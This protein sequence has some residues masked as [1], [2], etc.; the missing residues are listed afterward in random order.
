[1]LLTSII[2]AVNI[3]DM[4]KRRYDMTGRAAKAAATKQRICDCAIE[5]YCSR[6]IEDFTLEEVAARAA[7]TVQT[8]LR[9]FGSKDE[10]IYAALDR[11]ARGGVFLKPT[12]PGDAAAAVT[13]FFEIYESIGDMVMRRLNEEMRRPALKPVLDEGRKHHRLGVEAAFAPH[14]ALLSAAP[15][16]RLLAALTVL[17]DVYV[18]KLV[19]RDMGFSRTASEAI[20]LQMING[21]IQ[22][23]TTD[24][25]ADPLAKLVRRREP[26]A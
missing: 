4:K 13:A 14:L 19:R 18:W 22:R 9:D 15:R 12:P 6:A 3:A 21:V 16:A 2:I 5:L 24:G 25:K 8:I 20:V 26:A 17:T 11:M 7:T 1:M 23:E 10:L